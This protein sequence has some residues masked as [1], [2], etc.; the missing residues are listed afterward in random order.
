MNKSS[1]FY[2]VLR[3]S[4]IV[5][6]LFW[7]VFIVIFGTVSFVL[8]LGSKKVP[9]IYEIEPAVG[10]PGTKVTIRGKNFGDSPMSAYLEMGGST[11]T[12]NSFQLWTDSE[13]QVIL[14]DRK[15]VV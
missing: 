1:S 2:Y 5:R 4:P 15:S 12:A 8:T 3:K 6:T 9:E 13:I 11:L 14:P 10:S 7:V